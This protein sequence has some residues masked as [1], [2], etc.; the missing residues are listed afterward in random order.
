MLVWP[1]GTTEPGVIADCKTH[2]VVSVIPERGAG[3]DI[4]HFKKAI[5]EAEKNIHLKVL[6]ADAGYDS[7]KA[8]TFA[9]KRRGARA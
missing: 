2:L 6:T 3:P 9:R 1:M 4:K 5:L 7:E 8:H